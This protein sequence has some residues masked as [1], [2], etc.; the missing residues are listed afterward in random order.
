[1]DDIANPAVSRFRTP[2]LRAFHQDHPLHR[3]GGR[4]AVHDFLQI[5][6]PGRPPA[7]GLRRRALGENQILIRPGRDG[8]QWVGLQAV[9]RRPSS[10]ASMMEIDQTPILA[11][12]TTSQI[13]TSIKMM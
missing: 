2:Y 7:A 1:M 4:E 3:R 12:M 11:A 5:G 8:Q 6:G 13:M 9:A 10:G